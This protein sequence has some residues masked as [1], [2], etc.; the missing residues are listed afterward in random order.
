MTRSAIAV[1]A[2][3]AAIVLLAGFVHGTWTQR[4]YSSAELDAAVE[5]LGSI[6]TKVEGWTGTEAESNT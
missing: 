2:S 4:W 6:P 5:R 3:A 1:V